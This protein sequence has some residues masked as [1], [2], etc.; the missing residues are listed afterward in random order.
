MDEIINC[1]AGCC[2]IHMTK[3]KTKHKSDIGRTDKS[4]ILL[5]DKEEK[6]VL[7]VQS[8]G[9]L[10]GIPKG[11]V[12]DDEN[13]SDAAIRET[14]EETGIVVDITQLSDDVLRISNSLYYFCSIKKREVK[15]QKTEENDVNSIGWIK[16]EC[17]KKMLT[18]KTIKLTKHSQNIL[19]YFLKFE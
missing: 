4:G 6:C 14:A 13:Y 8:R 11:T 7:I 16:L 15:V 3:Y 5:F 17:L 19:K 9:K 10:W 12:K 1:H 18:D 2:K